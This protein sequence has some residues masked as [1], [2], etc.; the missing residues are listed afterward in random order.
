[1]RTYRIV[2]GV[3]FGIVAIVSLA[4]DIFIYARDK[5]ITWV[6]IC[7]FVVCGVFSFLEFAAAFGA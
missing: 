1:M 6:G 7:G 4:K 5:E 3:F 2:I